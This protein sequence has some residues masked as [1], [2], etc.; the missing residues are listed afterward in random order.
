MSQL[1]NFD[2]WHVDEN[3]PFGSG[4]SE[5]KWL[6][7][8]ETKQTGIFKYPKIMSTGEITGEY[9]AEKLA[10]DIAAVLGIECASVDIGIY[11]NRIGSM[12]YN[13]LGPDEELIEGIQYIVN[14]YP[15]YNGDKFIDTKS[16]KIYSIQ[17]IFESLKDTGLEQDFLKIPIFDALIGNSDRHHS[18]WAVVKNI[19]TG[20]VRVSPLYDNGSSLCCLVNNDKVQHYMG[21]LLNFESLIYGKSKSIIGW[22]DTKKPRHLELISDIAHNFYDDTISIINKMNETLS[23][24]VINSIVYGYDD[25]VITES[26]KM[27]LCRFLMERKNRIVRIY[28]EK[29]G[30]NEQA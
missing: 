24:D 14:K 7:N 19:Q 26:I 2:K 15:N 23:E 10:S 29:E 28:K 30:D 1:I 13:V 3:H 17:M 21:S 11:N 8:P 5:K 6:I 27:L 25:M 16:G 4:A 18:N 20:V 9:W 12:S 22:K